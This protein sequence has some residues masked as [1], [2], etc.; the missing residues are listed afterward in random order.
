LTIAATCS[1]GL[2]PSA[3]AATPSERNG[4]PAVATTTATQSLAFGVWTE[5][6]FDQTGTA[7]AAF[8]FF[9]RSPVLL[10]VTDAFCRGDE[11]RVLDHGYPI[12]NTSAVATDPSCDDSPFVGG[13]WEAWRDQTYSKGRFLLEPGSH[14]VKVRVTDSP[15]GGGGAFIRIDKRPVS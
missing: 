1:F 15:F 2:A 10:R 14:R 7:T 13:P 12:F 11:F 4:G 6:S 9:S 3:D 8:T 5:F